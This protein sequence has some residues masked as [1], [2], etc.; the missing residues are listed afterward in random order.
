MVSET[1]RKSIDARAQVFDHPGSRRAN[2][3]RIPRD[4][5]ALCRL[6]SRG[7][8]CRHPPNRWSD[9]ECR[10]RAVRE[11]ERIRRQCGRAAR[12]S[13]DGDRQLRCN[14]PGLNTCG[15]ARWGDCRWYAAAVT[16]AGA[17]VTGAMRRHVIGRDIGTCRLI[18]SRHPMRS[19]HLPG[20]LPGHLHWVHRHG[21]GQSGSKPDSPN[22]RNN[23]HPQ[24]SPHTRKLVSSW[25]DAS[26][27]D[28]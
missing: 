13:I 27:H 6:T 19:R 12:V 4:R 5:S 2:V 23:P 20:G 8:R 26:D 25:F 28:G 3:L 21:R 11:G 1:P 17:V 22:G 9:R 18:H 15:N 7:C 10:W 16:D 14:H 24:R